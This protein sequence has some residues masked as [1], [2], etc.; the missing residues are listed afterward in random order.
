M[1]LIDRHSYIG[2]E[3]LSLVRAMYLYVLWQKTKNSS[4]SSGSG[5]TL[6][7]LLSLGKNFSFSNLINIGES[8]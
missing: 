7:G 2:K 1:L 4:S 8:V 6:L 5:V 3:L